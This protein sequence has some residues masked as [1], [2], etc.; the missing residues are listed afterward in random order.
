[1]SQYTPAFERAHDQGWQTV[2]IY[3]SYPLD[4]YLDLLDRI[5]NGKGDDWLRY[6]S[7]KGFIDGSLGARTGYQWKPYYVNGTPGTPDDIGLLVIS[8][9]Q[10]YNWSK[11]ADSL[12]LQ[13]CLHAIGDQANSI[14]LDTFE[15]IFTENGL[16]DRRFRIEHAQQIISSDVSRFR[17][18]GIIASMQP[19]HAIDDGRWAE[20]VLGPDR[21]HDL[22]VFNSL[23]QNGTRVA[24]GSDWSVAPA[25]GLWG[26]YAAA[27]RRTLDGNNPNGWC[28][29]QII[30]VEDALYSY[31][32]QASY[33]GFTE[34]SVGS[35]KIGY[36]ADLVLFDQNLLTI[37][38]INLPNVKILT[39]VVDGRVVWQGN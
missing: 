37:N 1:M 30:S 11:A 34:N 16:R 9:E 17:S 4:A 21:I 39:T 15:Q 10:L 35:L 19:Y 33:A 22:Y 27:T 20:Q 5:K 18:L 2:R 32:S 6:G 25:S 29:E 12:G 38:P 24:F 7:L 3:D 31:T 23:L 14:V 13:V 26:L 36:L 8:Q 28:P